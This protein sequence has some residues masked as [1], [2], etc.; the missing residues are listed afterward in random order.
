MLYQQI[1][2]T[3]LLE[4]S[5]REALAFQRIMM[6]PSS[7]GC[8]PS[9]SGCAPSSLTPSN[10][11]YDWIIAVVLTIFSGTGTIVGTLMMKDA[12]KK[13]EDLPIEKQRR[14][15]GIPV[16]RSW[17]LGFLLVCVFPTPLDFLALGMAS[18]S[19]VF[20]VGVS[21]SVVMGQIIAPRFFFKNEKLGRRE[22]FGTAG[23]VCG[24][25]LVCAFGNR[26]STSYSSEKIKTLWGAP[27][28]LALFLPL[29]VLWIVCLLLFHAP[30]RIKK[31]IKPTILFL[32]V[33]YIPSYIGGMQTICFKAF[34]EITNNGNPKE[35]EDIAPYCYIIAVV[36]LATS[37]LKYM[38]MGAE[39]FQAT[40]YFPA[41]NAGIML[42]VS[43]FGAVF[44]EEYTALHPV[45]FPCGMVL[46]MSGIAVLSSKDPTDSASVA[47]MERREL[48]SDTE[49]G[50][51][52]A[53]EG[54]K[55]STKENGNSTVA[56]VPP[57]KQKLLLPY[58]NME[59]EKEKGTVTD[60]E[61]ES[62]VDFKVKVET[63]RDAATSNTDDVLVAREKL[64]IYAGDEKLSRDGAMKVLQVRGTEN[65]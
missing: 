43:L 61:T 41:Y 53:E 27:T 24:A 14:I 35:W 33:A 45:G 52:K 58:T 50:E 19:L 16:T 2:A 7:S 62:E 38:N 48:A 23:I 65:T 8:A 28:F 49:K 54:K 42:T 4:F 36:A 44:Y 40:K 13:L 60:T 34:S 20:P 47:A 59:M 6:T 55:K 64:R 25:V 51:T 30:K 5:P 11:E 9:S 37:Q 18:A 15:G 29:T 63:T 26:E 39:R 31:G 22:W 56:I 32:C 46:I 10:N 12:Y 57:W 3:A 1:V 21:T 17:V